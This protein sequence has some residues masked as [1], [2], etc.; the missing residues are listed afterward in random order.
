MKKIWLFA[1]YGALAEKAAP[2]LGC[3]IALTLRSCRARAAEGHQ[4]NKRCFHTQHVGAPERVLRSWASFFFIK[5]RMSQ[6]YYSNKLAI[7]FR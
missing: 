2:S 3:A 7:F 5:F 4:D 1:E 6:K